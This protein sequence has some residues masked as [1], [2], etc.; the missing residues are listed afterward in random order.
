MNKAHLPAVWDVWLLDKEHS[1]MLSTDLGV[2]VAGASAPSNS[3][4]PSLVAV[5]ALLHTRGW[6]CCTG[7]LGPGQARHTGAPEVLQYAPRSRS[8]SLC[9]TACSASSGAGELFPSP[10]CLYIDIP[11]GACQRHCLFHARHFH[12]L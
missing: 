4:V 3:M 8:V 9:R 6:S 12:H 11:G 1:L 5:P 2:A 10:P 7:F